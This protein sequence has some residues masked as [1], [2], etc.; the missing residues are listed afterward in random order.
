MSTKLHLT[1]GDKVEI[2]LEQ[3]EVL[4]QMS[5]QGYLE[6]ERRSGG[7]VVIAVPHI[8]FTEAVKEGAHRAE[9]M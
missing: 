2:K 9:F 8:V 6:A 3:G 5:T 1:N 7:R 4:S